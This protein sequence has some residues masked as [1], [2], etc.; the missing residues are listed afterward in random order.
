M[1]GNAAYIADE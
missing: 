1:E